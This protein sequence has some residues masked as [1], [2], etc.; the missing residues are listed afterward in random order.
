MKRLRPS[1]TGRSE[2]S[3]GHPTGRRR[4]GTWRSQSRN[5]ARQLQSSW[6]GWSKT[7]QKDWKYFKLPMTTN[8][9]FRPLIWWSD[10]LKRTNEELGWRWCF[11]MRNLCCDWSVLS[12]WKWMSN[13]RKASDIYRRR[14]NDSLNNLQKKGCFIIK[15]NTTKLLIV[16]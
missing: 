10:R 2:R 5:I 16:R 4:I 14:L 3:S 15:G 8:D 1:R 13:G 12:S 7:S 6:T 11:Q 9:Y